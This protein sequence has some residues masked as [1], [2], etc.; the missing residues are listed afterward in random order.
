M[1]KVLTCMIDSILHTGHEGYLLVKF[2]G[3]D[4]LGKGILNN[5]NINKC[6]VFVRYTDN[7]PR[8]RFH[9]EKNK[10]KDKMKIFLF[11]T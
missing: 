10:I 5:T 1:C 4:G 3:E 9:Q 8:K 2:F 11:S 6:L 7:T